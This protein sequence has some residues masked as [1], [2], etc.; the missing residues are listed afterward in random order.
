MASK[1]STLDITTFRFSARVTMFSLTTSC[2]SAICSNMVL[3]CLPFPSMISLIEELINKNVVL[4]TTQSRKKFLSCNQNTLF[5][6]LS[7]KGSCCSFH[8]LSLVLILGIYVDFN[9]VGLHG[10][11]GIGGTPAGGFPAAPMVGPPRRPWMKLYAP[12]SLS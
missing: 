6:L 9:L 8:L 2:P 5:I 10:Y 12:I 4:E 1:I 11:S 7:D 3:G